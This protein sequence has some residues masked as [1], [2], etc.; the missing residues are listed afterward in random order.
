M[1]TKKHEKNEPGDKIR[2]LII[3]LYFHFYPCE[4][5]G[6]FVYILFS[7]TINEVAS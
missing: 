3:F 1:G 7:C 4:M 5:Q 2:K 6:N